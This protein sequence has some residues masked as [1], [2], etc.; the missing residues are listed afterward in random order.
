MVGLSK[1]HNNKKRRKNSEILFSAFAYFSQVGVTM[2]ATILVG[3][4]LG[5]YLDR[6]LGTEPWLLL[7]C[8]L[9]GLGAAIR[10]L[11]KDF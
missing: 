3:V 2:A 10:S 9:L 7:I 1:E 6:W 5:K 11:L 8:S 4:L